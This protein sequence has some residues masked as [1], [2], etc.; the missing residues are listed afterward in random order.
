MNMLNHLF[1][2]RQL[3]LISFVGVVVL[4]PILMIFRRKRARIVITLLY[5]IVILQM[6]IGFRLVSIALGWRAFDSVPQ[7]DLTPFWSYA[8]FHNA[9]IRWQVY[10]NVF[11]FIPFGFM[12]PWCSEWLQRLW[13][14]LLI[15]A[16][17][18]ALTEAAQY[19][20]RIGLCETDDVIHNTLGA[21]IGYGY[22]RLLCR[23][24]THFRG[25]KK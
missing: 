21:V 17:F 16:I 11:L 2:M 4:P 1:T 19:F 23:I 12:L 7:I 5:I 18:A 22:W 9:A 8:Q 25:D 14:V 20:F 13:K 15:S 3:T 24:Q 6:V 10:M